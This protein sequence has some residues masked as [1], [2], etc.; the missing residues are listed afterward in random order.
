MLNK[1]LDCAPSTTVT[2]CTKYERDI[3][4]NDDGQ[5]KVQVNFYVEGFSSVKVSTTVT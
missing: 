1:I 4:P 2:D 3:S 5:S